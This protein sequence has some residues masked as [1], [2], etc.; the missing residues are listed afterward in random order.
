MV[1]IDIAPWGTNPPHTQ[2]R[3]SE[4]FSVLEGPVQVGFIIS[5][6]EY[7]LKV[8][9]LQQGYVFTLVHFQRNVG[10]RNAVA[11]AALSC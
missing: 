7:P 11:T 4:I 2:P 8:K 1:S 5:S 6:P 10:N 3:A 9:V